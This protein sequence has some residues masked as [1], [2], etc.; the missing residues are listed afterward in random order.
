MALAYLL[1]PCLQH[2]NRAGVNNVDGWFEVFR[3]DTDDRATIYTD[4]SGTL[5][6]ARNV[7]DNNG[8]VVMI[9]ESGVAY[10][11]AMYLPNGELVYTQQPVF[12]VGSGGVASG[13]TEI[14]SSDGSINVDKTSVGSDTTFDITV[15]RDGTDLLEYVRCDGA[16][17]IP[18]SYI[19]RPTYTEGTIMVG[20]QGLVLS[21]G[22][23]Y[24]VTAHVR[25]TKSVQRDPFYDEI[26]IRFVID[27][28][29]SQ[30]DCVVEKRIVDYS[31]GLSQEFEV[32]TDVMPSSNCELLFVIDGHDV[33]NGSFELLDVEAHKV[34]SGSPSIPSGVLSRVQAANIYQEKL[35]AG[36]NITIED[37]VISATGG[38]GGSTYTA[39]D[40][41]DITNNEISVKVGAGLKIGSSTV[42][43]VHSL[44][45][46]ESVYD[47]YQGTYVNNDICPL[48]PDLISRIKAPGGLTITLEKNYSNQRFPW[49]LALY[50][51]RSNA[52]YMPQNYYVLNGPNGGAYPIGH[53]LTYDNS[54]YNSSK[55]NVSL[56]TIEANYAEY[57]LGIL[58]DAGGDFYTAFAQLSG[59]EP[60]VVATYTDETPV[61]NCVYVSNPLPEYA[62][63]DA[64]KFLTVDASGNANWA[65][66]PLPTPLATDVSKVLVVADTSGNVE[67]SSL[68]MHEVPAV[69]SYDNGK[70]LKATYDGWFGSYEW[71]DAPGG[72]TVYKIDWSYGVAQ[73]LFTIDD[74]EFSYNNNGEVT[75]TSSVVTSVCMSYSKIFYNSN[76]Y[77]HFADIPG[78][79]LG[80]QYSGL[81]ITTPQVLLSP[82]EAYNEFPASYD[83]TLFYTK[84]STSHVIKMSVFSI[85]N[86]QNDT[87]TLFFS[88]THA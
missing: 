35:I 62:Q 78:T 42:Q 21:A 49:Y 6:P 18:D 75:M 31:I 33:Q 28:G 20:E 79:A 7:I 88:V 46:S 12:T 11:V 77:Y 56:A 13:S 38:G 37:N 64:G 45:C 80:I 43:T 81:S 4:F 63:A 30:T 1:D 34:Y 54:D 14:T 25:A 70:F 23:Y 67:W 86:T 10:R 87:G 58:Y 52:H 9:A 71:A 59:S 44:T 83:I 53:V 40:G 85:R 60:E 27:D 16:T 15:A 17:Q 82:S 69:N 68:S 57:R 51:P 8:R 3:M 41:I 22:H 76:G 36:T 50:S 2:Q 66:N 48:T 26:N 19:Y 29:T 73:T 39:G 32:S 65:D 47:S 84:S 5:A 74:I 55:S 24:H 72:T 61:Q